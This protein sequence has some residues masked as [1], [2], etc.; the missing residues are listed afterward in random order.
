MNFV[1]T[2]GIATKTISSPIGNRMD[3]YTLNLDNMAQRGWLESVLLR[4]Q[5]SQKLR[6]K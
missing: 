3:I 2:E 1:S 5:M 4:V 6:L